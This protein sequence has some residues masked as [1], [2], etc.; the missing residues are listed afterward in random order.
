MARRTGFREQYYTGT[1]KSYSAGKIGASNPV[2]LYIR[3]GQS[4]LIFSGLTSSFGLTSF[5]QRDMV[6]PDQGILVAHPGKSM[7]E[8][9]GWIKVILHMVKMT[10]FRTRGPLRSPNDP[11]RT[12]DRALTRNET[13]HMAR[14][15]G[16]REQYYTGTRNSYSAGKIGASDQVKLCVVFGRFFLIFSGLTSSFG[17]SLCM[18]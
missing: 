9:L 14:R 8:R 5:V 4:F 1:R 16:F 12:Q 7:G 11:P 6:S 13:S 2:K 17:L 3:F 10:E 18:Q 15:T